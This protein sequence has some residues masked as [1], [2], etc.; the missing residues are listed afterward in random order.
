[1]KLQGKITNISLDYLTHKPKIEIQLNRQEDLFT[2]EFTNLKEN[3]LD[4]ELKKHREKRSI[5]ANGY[6]WTLCDQ[7]ANVVNTTKEKVYK[8]AIHEVGQFEVLPIKNEA[9]DTFI[10]AW[11]SHGIGWI[12]ESI[13]D[14]K[15]DGFTRVI[16]Y[17]GSSVYDTKAMSR[18][19]EWVVEEAKNLG[20]QTISDKEFQS[21][22]DEY[23]KEYMRRK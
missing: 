8:K 5:N 19:I 13:G 23:E 22:I 2:D 6:L 7:I 14:S 11:T 16:A 15:L 10:N 12:C 1:M 4:I 21:M 20:I 17:Y 3:Q 18:I 9:V